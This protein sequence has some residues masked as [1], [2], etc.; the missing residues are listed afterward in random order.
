MHGGRVDAFS[1]GADQGSTFTLRL[2]AVGA[3]AE[4]PVAGASPPAPST[5]IAPLRILVVDDNVDSATV[6]CRL[7]YRKGHATKIAHDGP[8]ALQLAF[9]ERPEVPLPIC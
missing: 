6:L 4:H 1:G 7:L 8:A 5:A 3:P 2:P 9:A